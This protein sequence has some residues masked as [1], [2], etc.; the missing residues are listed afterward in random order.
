MKKLVSLVLGLSLVMVTHTASAAVFEDTWTNWLDPYTDEY[1]MGVSDD[2]LGTPEIEY[3]SVFTSEADMLQSV[4]I[5]SANGWENFNSLFIN[6]YAVG[7]K[8][9]DSWDYLVH[10]GGRDRSQR[11]RIPKDGIWSVK[12]PLDYEYTLASG[13]GVRQGNPNGIHKKN[14]KKMDKGNHWTWSG[15]DH[16]GND[17][18]SYSFD[19]VLIDLS[20]G[21]SI[22]FS[23]WCA[24]DVMGGEM[25]PVPEPATLALLGIGLLALAGAARKRF[26]QRLP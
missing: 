18:W 12:N 8:G 13:D 16:L 17:L 7:A 21:F 19:R 4:Q 24:N 6:S 3:L 10:D 9:F 22:A 26:P 1:N 20:Q 14:L 25:N 23:P 15:Q 5:A 2:D 11:H